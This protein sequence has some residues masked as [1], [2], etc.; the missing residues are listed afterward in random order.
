MDVQAANTAIA[1]DALMAGPRI[2]RVGASGQVRDRPSHAFARQLAGLLHPG[3]ELAFVELVVL[4]DV[5]VARVL[6]LGF[7][8]RDRAQRRAAEEQ[9]FDLIAAIAV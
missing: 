4:V 5:E 1:T 2:F 6:A 8:R 7:A 9:A 3:G